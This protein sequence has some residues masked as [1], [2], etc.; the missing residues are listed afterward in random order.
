[1]ERARAG[2][3]L[4]TRIAEKEDIRIGSVEELLNTWRRVVFWINDVHIPPRHI[5]L[6]AKRNTSRHWLRAHHYDASHPVCFEKLAQFLF[7]NAA[8]ATRRVTH[9][10]FFAIAHYDPGMK[11]IEILAGRCKKNQIAALQKSFEPL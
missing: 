1:M 9:R 2:L 11:H 4:H 6:G 5:I 3:D 8:L 10:N 7:H